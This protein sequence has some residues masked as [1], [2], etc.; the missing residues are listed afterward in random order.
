MSEYLIKLD[1]RRC[2]NCKACELLCKASK[3]LPRGIKLGPLVTVRPTKLIKG[4]KVISAF[5]PCFHCEKPWCVKV[6]PTKAMIRREEDGIVYVDKDLCVGCKSCIVV[7]PWNIPQFDETTGK[8]LK[9]DY[10]IDRIESG[11]EPA[12]VSACSAHALTFGKANDDSM[13]VRKAFGKSQALKK[14]WGVSP[15]K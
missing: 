3:C 15:L 1:L 5:K 13:K 11:L 9:C 10:C 4:H 12:C 2:V 7:C 8:V 14:D 6:C